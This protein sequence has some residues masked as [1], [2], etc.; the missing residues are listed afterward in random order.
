MLSNRALGLLRQIFDATLQLKEWNKT[1][2]KKL[3]YILLAKM[4]I[5]VCHTGYTCI[6]GH[7][8]IHSLSHFV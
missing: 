8:H 6:H 7:R 3:F 1:L 5:Y 4:L 2:C